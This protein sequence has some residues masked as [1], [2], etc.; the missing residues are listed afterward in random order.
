LPNQVQQQIRPNQHSENRRQA[1]AG[2]ATQGQGYLLL[3]GCQ[4]RNNGQISV[5]FPE[6]RY[7]TTAQAKQS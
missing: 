1:G 2:H 4:R 6:W 7:G 3:G 5:A